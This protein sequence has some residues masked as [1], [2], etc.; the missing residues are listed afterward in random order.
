M[1]DSARYAY[2]F[3]EKESAMIQFTVHGVCYSM[4]NSRILTKGR[5][6]EH[7]K[8][9]QFREDFALQVPP[10]AKLSLGSRRRPLQC[11]VTVYYPSYQQDLDCAVVYDLLEKCGVVSNDRY[12]RAKIEVA[13]IDRSDPRVIIEVSEIGKK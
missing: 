11:R 6:I 8:C 1:R 7:P 4:K 9:R 3:E 12:C 10:S 2:L 13:L 5:T